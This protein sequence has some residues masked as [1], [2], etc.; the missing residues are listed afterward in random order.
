M[1]R[2][3]IV[4]QFT[5]LNRKLNEEDRKMAAWN[6]LAEMQY[7]SP[8]LG[9]EYCVVRLGLGF[10]LDTSALELWCFLPKQ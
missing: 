5:L 7:S 6:S 8:G 2:L 10:G 1:C 9:L 3:A 4:L